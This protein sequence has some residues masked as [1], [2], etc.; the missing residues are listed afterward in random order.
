MPDQEQPGLVGASCP[1][2]TQVQA[3][4]RRRREDG[5]HAQQEREPRRGLAPQ[6]EEHPDRDRRARPRDARHERRGLGHADRERRRRAPMASSPRV[7]GPIRSTTRNSTAH[8]RPASPPPPTA[9]AS[10]SSIAAAHQQADDDDGHRAD[11]DQ[12]QAPAGRVAGHTG[13]GT[14]RARPAPWPTGRAG[15]TRPRPASVPTWHAT[16][17]ARPS[18]I[19][20]PAQQRP[21]QDEVRGTRHRQELGESLHRPEHDR[22]KVPQRPLGYA[23]SEARFL[24]FFVPRR[25]R[26]PPSGAGDAALAPARLLAA[27]EDRDGRGDEDASSTCR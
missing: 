11:G 5:R 7:R 10:V 22:L 16:S 15:S 14:R 8:Q 27:E 21:R 3:L 20:V 1:A 12:P 19:R 9:S 26:R 13:R 23:P 25:R 18:S 17:N 24:P 6:P 4:V 2:S